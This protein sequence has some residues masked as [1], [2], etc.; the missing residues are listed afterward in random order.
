MIDSDLHTL[1]R[2]PDL[3]ALSRAAAQALVDDVR[4]VLGTQ[5]RY[6]LALAGGSTPKRF[7]ELLASGAEGTLPWARIHLFWGDERYVSPGDA[8]TNRHL[9]QESLLRTAD[10]PA[11]NVHPDGHGLAR[12][13]GLVRMRTPIVEGC[14]RGDGIRSDGSVHTICNFNVGSGTNASVFKGTCIEEN[15]F[16]Y[17]PTFRPCPLRFDMDI[18]APCDEEIERLIVRSLRSESE[19]A[20]ALEPRA[21]RHYKRAIQVLLGTAYDGLSPAKRRQLLASLCREK[22]RLETEAPR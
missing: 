22:K 2:H 18:P 8:R 11:S 16:A 12:R 17:H 4:T 3:E 14:R 19:D 15:E 21:L 10:I 5:D 7:Y 1:H 9:V 13:E 6:T 20:S